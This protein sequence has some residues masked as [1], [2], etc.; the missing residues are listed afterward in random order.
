MEHCKMSK[1]LNHSTVSKLWTKNGLKLM[2]YQ[3]AS[4]VLTKFN[5]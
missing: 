2:I 4:I 5:I 1:L 3:T